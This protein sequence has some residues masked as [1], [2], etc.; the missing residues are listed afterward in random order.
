MLRFKMA[1]SLIC[2]VCLWCHRWPCI[3][4]MITSSSVARYALCELPESGALE[5]RKQPHKYC[6]STRCSCAS[7]NGGEHSTIQPIQHY[8]RVCHDQDCM[9]SSHNT[10]VVVNASYG[11]SAEQMNSA[12]I[13][14]AVARQSSISHLVTRFL[15][16][17]CVAISSTRRQ[18]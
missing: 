5:E 16:G 11:S 10:P 2:R 3:N 7:F 8:H 13:P 6:C 17:I 14:S 4:L 1:T 15:I 18:L 9:P 12:R